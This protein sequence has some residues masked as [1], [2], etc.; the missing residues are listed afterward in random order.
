MKTIEFAIWNNAS[1]RFCWPPSL[2]YLVTSFWTAP[3]LHYLKSGVFILMAKD[4]NQVDYFRKEQKMADEKQSGSFSSYCS[5]SEMTL[6]SLFQKYDQNSGT[7]NVFPFCLSFVQ[8]LPKKWRKLRYIECFSFLFIFRL[9]IE[10]KF[11]WKHSQVIYFHDLK[12]GE[13]R[14]CGYTGQIRREDDWVVSKIPTNSCI[15]R[16]SI[17][18]PFLGSPSVL[19]IADNDLFSIHFNPIPYGGGPYGSPPAFC[20]KSEKWAGP[21]A[22]S[23]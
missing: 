8:S 9:Q 1:H 12:F 21:K 5:A 20:P 23:L 16:F 13:S 11:I 2:P 6:Y 14:L 10:L 7:S 19:F 4:N 3:Y 18:A 15:F 22:L 17:L